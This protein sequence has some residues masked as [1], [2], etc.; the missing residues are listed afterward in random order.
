[1]TD[2]DERRAD[3]ALLDDWAAGDSA[4]ARELLRRY[5]GPLVRFFDRKLDGQVE[6][7]VQDTLLGC[8]SGRD[9]FRREAGFRSYVFGIA[10]NV[11]F[12]ALR[13]KHRGANELDVETS[14]L[15]GLEPSPSGLVAHKRELRVLLEALRRLPIDTQVLLELYHWQ[16]LSGPELAAALGI[17]ERALRSR[18]HRATG[19][20]REAAAVVAESP[21]LLA[22][23]LANFEEWAQGLPAAKDLPESPD[24]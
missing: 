18:L 13:A 22:S 21:E 6:D 1:M 11:L 20:L 4:A 9:R 12:A 2:D 8:I 3:F 5:T 23:S 14:C 19:A 24:E 10:R 7:L 15:A 17:G 16:K